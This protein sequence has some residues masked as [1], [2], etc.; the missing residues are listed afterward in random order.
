MACVQR[1]L[2]VR[3]FGAEIDVA[4]GRAD[5]DA[6]DRHALDE[7]EGIAFH[8][9]AVG[10][11]AAVALVGVADDVL[12]LAHRRVVDRLPLDAGRE[13]SAAAAAQ[14][15]LGDFIDDFDRLHA[16]SAFQAL[17]AVVLRGSRSSETGSV[18]PQRA[19]VRRVWRF[20]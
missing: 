18:M 9:H 11:R 15:G 12:L 19:N 5:R 10:K 14:A 4:P 8:D 1:H 3:I 13:A 6:R 17:V 2:G 20:M 16:E 7:Q